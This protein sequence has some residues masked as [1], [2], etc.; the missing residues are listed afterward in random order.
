MASKI[1]LF[2]ILFIGFISFVNTT[3]KTVIAEE[4]H[5]IYPIPA[6]MVGVVRTPHLDQSSKK[7]LNLY[8]N[9]CEELNIKC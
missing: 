3:S 8:F 5:S 2:I 6:N 4:N 1:T 7:W 9:Q